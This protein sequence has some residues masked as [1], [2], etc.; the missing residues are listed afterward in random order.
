MS[1][2]GVISIVLYALA[3][4]LIAEASAA[5]IWIITDRHHP[6]SAGPQVRVIE[7]DAPAR[8]V[9]ELSKQLPA[10]P[11]RAAQLMR[12]RLRR[13][14]PDLQQRLASASQG[15]VDAWRCG[16]TKL[17]AIVVDRRYVV[18][19]ESNVERAL[20]RIEQYRRSKQ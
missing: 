1:S 20:A 14:G 6:V 9:G 3:A 8:R 4:A 7:L 17:P 13:G 15:V 12:E 5:E 19:G 10:E 16:V 2:P 18:Y 11:S